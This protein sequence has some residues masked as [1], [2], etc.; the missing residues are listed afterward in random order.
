LQCFIDIRFGKCRANEPALKSRRCYK[1]IA[2]FGSWEINEDI[3]IRK[4]C[5]EIEQ[6]LNWPPSDRWAN[7][8]FESLSQMIF[9]RTKTRLSVSTLKRVWGK[10]SYDNLP[11]AN[12]LNTLAVYNGYQSWKDFWQRSKEEL[13]EN[14]TNNIISKSGPQTIRHWW[15]RPILRRAIVMIILIVIGL[16]VYFLIS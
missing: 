12:T 16:I 15:E 10:V 13:N 7:N 4:C 9:E 8:D 5:S 11:S 1:K 14:K 6:N 2:I 3:L